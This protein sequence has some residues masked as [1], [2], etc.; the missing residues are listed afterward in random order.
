MYD[1]FRKFLIHKLKELNYQEE[2]GFD[3]S[4]SIKDT[5]TLDA[6]HIESKSYKIYTM[7]AQPVQTFKYLTEEYERQFQMGE[8]LQTVI[9]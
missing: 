6:I 7:I 5:K 1:L 9:K 8:I 3:K 4:L 2:N